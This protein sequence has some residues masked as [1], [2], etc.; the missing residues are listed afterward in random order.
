MHMRISLALVL[1]GALATSGCAGLQ[2][3]GEERD[4]AL[5]YFVPEPYLV[6]SISADCA[7]TAN[8]ISLPGQRRSVRFNNGYGTA[9]LSLALSNGIITAVGQKT[10]S[11]IPET[12]TAAAGLAKVILPTTTAAEGP[13]K[14]S[15]NPETHLYAIKDGI[16][17]KRE[18]IRVAGSV[19]DVSGAM[20]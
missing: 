14:P 8:V 19:V 11:K 4:D 2:F 13:K 9:D 18:A 17:E 15:C 16:P 10:D 6:V 20:R 5:T 3:S 7:W 1:V 12:I